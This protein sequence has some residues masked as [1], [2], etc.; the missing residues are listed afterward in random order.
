MRSSGVLACISG[1]AVAVACSSSGGGGRP[2]DSGA[3]ETSLEPDSG[4]A[5]TGTDSGS[6]DAT[7]CNHVLPEFV[8]ANLTLSKACSPYSAPLPVLVGD[9]A[10][11]PVLTIEPG[12]TVTF[13]SNAY[14][15]IGMA[16][17]APA[18][19]GLVAVGTPAELKAKVG[20]N[21]TL[22]DVFAVLAGTDE[23]NATETYRDV[24]LSRRAASTHG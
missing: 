10:N 15:S 8:T 7:L 24:R 17:D 18:P 4:G 1:V 11:H 12:V 3:G 16:Q 21:A 2:Q 14:L 23:D 9:S 20:P 19:G 6:G 13:S 5:E 22:D